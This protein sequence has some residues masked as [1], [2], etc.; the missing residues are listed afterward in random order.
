MFWMRHATP[1]SATD[2]AI[3]RLGSGVLASLCRRSGLAEELLPCVDLGRSHRRRAGPVRRRQ[4]HE[5]FANC[6]DSARALLP[7]NELITF[8]YPRRKLRLA[9]RVWHCAGI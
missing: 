7:Q 1:R 4:Q 3:P 8:G 5:K 6:A 9:V 2:T